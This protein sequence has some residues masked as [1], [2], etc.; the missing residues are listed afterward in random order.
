MNDDGRVL[1]LVELIYH[2]AVDRDAWRDVAAGS[3]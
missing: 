3:G 1:D 2:A